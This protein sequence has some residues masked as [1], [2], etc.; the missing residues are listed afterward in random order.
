VSYTLA[1]TLENL[2]LTGAALGSNATGNAA[3]N[4]LIGNTAAN[5]LDGKGGADSM[6]G[7]AGNDTYVVDVSGDIVTEISSGTDLVQSGVSFTL[8]TNLENLTLTGSSSNNAVGNTLANSL[9][10]NSGNNLLDGGSGTAADTMVGG[11]GNDTYVV[12]S[13]TDVVTEGTDPGVDTVQSSVT[14]TLGANLENLTLT[15]GDINGTGNTLANVLTGSDGNNLLNGGTGTAA[16]TMVGGLGNDNYVVDNASDVVSETAGEGIDLVQSS[17][18]YTLTADVDNLTLTGS[19]A[20]NGTGNVLGNVLTGNGG[21]NLLDGDGGADTMAGGLG[22]DTY[23]VDDAGDVVQEAVSG[24]T[25]R[26]Q[27]SVSFTLSADVEHLTLTGSAINGIGNGLA[28][29]LVGNAAANFL[30]GGAGV[31]TMAGGSG[32]DTYVVD[33]TGDVV[34]EAG[35][36]GVDLVLSA[37][38][39]TLATDVENLS[40][41]GISAINATGNDLAN[42]LVGNSGANL[43]NG[44]TGSDAMAGGDG[45]DTYVVDVAGDTVSELAN[46]GTDTVQ[47]GVSFTLAATLENLTLTGSGAISGNGNAI[48][49]V[50]TGNIGNNTLTGLGGNDILNGGLGT[51]NLL[52][53]TGDDT[54]VL[55]TASDSIVEAAGAGTDTVQSAATFTL[56]ANLENITLTGAGAIN[57]FGNAVANVLTGNGS[58]NLLN[59]GGGADTMMGGLGND[60]YVVDNAGDV[61][62]EAASA[63][64]DTV[65][66]GFNYT[67][68]DNLENLTL[69]GTATDGTG[70]ALNNSLTGTTGNNLLDGVTGNDA[71]IGLAGNDTYM[72]DSSTD[73]V[74]EA[75]SAGTDVVFASA[76]FTMGV[77]VETLTLTGIADLNGTGNTTANTLVGNSGANVL[78]GGGG[79]D[80]LTGDG[81]ADTFRYVATGDSGVGATLR[82]VIADFS[83]GDGDL[84]DLSAIDAVSAVAGNQDFSFIGSDAFSATDASGQLRFEA[85]ILYGST[86]ADVTAEFEIELTGVASMLAGDFVL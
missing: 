69:T 9:T 14:Y 10:G 56:G 5:I 54:Y 41:T 35:G 68:G 11:D 36:T 63:G 26:V 33:V 83:S 60:T 7:G 24:G 44:L 15:G 75:A 82:D 70:N 38:S 62:T 1:D 34:S 37:A 57:G 13:S 49:N 79:K 45:N 25:D 40:L 86:D 64:T 39:Y 59:G 42:A 48:D 50:L 23:V 20:I 18:T 12:D 6:D 53:G 4:V 80:T 51:D 61:V 30:D 8:G 58:S 67:L 27:S 72:V 3:D 73:V 77:N 43:L 71:M 66:V 55:D 76:S 85:G 17:V 52:G 28:N 2:T 81:G 21:A 47:S 32:N 31:D 74:T 46:E 78:Q 22:N 84:I 65:Q 16:D 19:S 29:N